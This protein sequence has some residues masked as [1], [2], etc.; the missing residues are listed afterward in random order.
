MVRIAIA[1]CWLAALASCRGLLGLE[2]RALDDA[3]PP[4]DA[5]CPTFYSDSDQ[6]G[7]GDP[8]AP[9]VAC[10]RPYGVSESNDDCDDKDRYRAPSLAEVCDE[11]DNDC[12]GTVDDNGC[13]NNCT[14][15]RRPAPDDATAYIRCT[16]QL[17]WPA[18]RAACGSWGFHLIYIETAEENTW[19]RSKLSF[20]STW[21]GGTD[22]LQPNR[23]IWG[24]GVAFWDSGQTLTYAAW[25][26]A[27]PENVDSEN[28]TEMDTLGWA[29]RQ[30]GITNGFVCER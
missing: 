12:N 15:L 2:D 22:Q 16:T 7:H 1:L 17:S 13:S 24:N 30:C 29:D 18:A 27:Q 10:V 14:A 6:D 28:C 20:A 21:L 9:I 3:T 25:A 11:L 19:L 26:T 4:D 5:N 8:D 23:W